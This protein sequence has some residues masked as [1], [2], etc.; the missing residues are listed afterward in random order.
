M[1][2]LY[3]DMCTSIYMCGHMMGVCVNTSVG[4]K[5]MAGVFLDHSTPY[6]SRQGLK[7]NLEL[8]IPDSLASQ[9]AQRIPCLSLPHAGITGV[10]PCPPS[11]H[12]GSGECYSDLHAHMVSAPFTELSSPLSVFYR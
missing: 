4:L 1:C 3:V 2:W 9:L 8:T 11:F 7:L 12:V 10:L 6:M 5:L